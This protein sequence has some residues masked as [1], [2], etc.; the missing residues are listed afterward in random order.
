MQCYLPARKCTHSL[1]THS[2]CYCYWAGKYRREYRPPRWP[3]TGPPTARVRTRVKQVP[4]ATLSTLLA[5]REFSGLENTIPVSLRFRD[6]I[7]KAI[8]P[9]LTDLCPIVRCKK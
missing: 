1:L 5:V 2:H 3:H 4:Y 6:L 7:P 8:P 9:K